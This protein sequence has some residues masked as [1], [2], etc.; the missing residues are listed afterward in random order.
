MQTAPTSPGLETD[1]PSTLALE[2]LPD[3]NLRDVDDFF[4][5]FVSAPGFNKLSPS[6]PH[7]RITYCE[8]TIRAFPTWDPVLLVPLR[9]IR[10]VTVTVLRLHSNF[11]PAQIRWLKMAFEV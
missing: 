11:C 3:W 2:T 10:T 8:R 1:P 5:T 4:A 7:S 9:T 6:F